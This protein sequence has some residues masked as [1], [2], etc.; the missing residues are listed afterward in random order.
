[1][2]NIIQLLPDNI[3]NQIAAG[4]VIQRPA[5][6]V[7]ELLENAVDADANQIILNI[8]DAGKTSIQV[9][10]NGKGMSES[11]ARM[12]FERHATSKLKSADDLFQLSTKGFRGEAMAS[13]AAIAHVELITQLEN[14]NIGTKILIEGS[15]VKKQEPCV[16][17]KGTI[18]A[19]KNLFFNVPARRNF[20]KSDNVE[21]KHIVEEFQ[22]IALTHPEVGFKLTHNNNVIYD[23]NAAV[24]RKRIVDIYGSSYNNR[25]VPIN[26]KTDIVEVTGFVVKPEFAKKSRGDQY[27]F[28]N[29]RFFKDSYL[30]HAVSAAFENLIPQKTYPSYF[31]Y[32]KV[33]PK[34]IDVNIHPTKTEIK[35]E[36]E[37]NIYS[38]LRSTIKL[39]LGVHNIAPSLDFERDPLFDLSLDYKNKPVKSPEVEFDPTY[40][41]FNSTSKPSGGGSGGGMT[42]AMQPNRSDW[43]NYY[44]IKQEENDA[45][46]K[47]DELIS[48][49]DNDAE[50]TEEL[51]NEKLAFKNTA[52]LQVH[53]KYMFTVVPSGVMVIHIPR[54]KERIL[55]DQ[56]M[57]QFIITPISSQQ[58]M[59]PVNFD[60]NETD[61]L[62][63]KQNEKSIKRLGFD[64]EWS[65]NSLVFSGFPEFLQTEKVNDCLENMTEKMKYENLDKGELAHVLI[66]SIA[67]AAVN[68]FKQFLKNEEMD[69]IANNLFS[70]AEHLHTANG[71]K[72]ISKLDISEVHKLFL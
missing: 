49:F 7:K 34:T 46:K 1:M 31:I 28:V 35:F 26:E 44:D 3:A 27:F 4:E 6:V 67:F 47:T 29:N 22:R 60:L 59:F 30:H 20:L 39:G 23:L 71:K 18:V 16:H 69:S 63:W 51:F 38:I 64:W 54:A 58:L 37:R 45:I 70:C 62:L 48:N 55:Y 33:D 66:S 13:I 32:L 2:S 65:G 8:K 36:D 5:S 42:K 25:L 41:P 50:N 19:V 40:N 43:E 12:C 56:M 24:L 21:T 52:F 53:Q 61:K 72:I 9:I 11:D 17:K 10:D 14:Q 57:E 15:K 68:P